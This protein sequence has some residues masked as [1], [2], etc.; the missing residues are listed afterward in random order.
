MAANKPD[1]GTRAVSAVAGLAATFV[2]RKL[3]TL[4]WTKITGKEPPEKTD[5]PAVALGEALVWGIAT[6]AVVATA[7]TLAVRAVSRG[8]IPAPGG[9][10]ADLVED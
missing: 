4:A 8:S 10:A 1:I 6:A 2:A 5:D 7:R 9:P 3:L